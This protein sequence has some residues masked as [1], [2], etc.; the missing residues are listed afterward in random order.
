MKYLKPDF[1][2]MLHDA[3]LDDTILTSFS[4]SIDLV[5]L[6]DAVNVSASLNLTPAD[7]AHYIAERGGLGLTVTGGTLK[8]ASARPA[9]VEGI[10]AD[11]SGVWFDAP[12]TG[13]Y[14]VRWYV[15]GELR[16]EEERDLSDNRYLALTTIDAQPGDVIQIALRV[17]LAISWWSRV[18][19]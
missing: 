14:D 3:G 2:P 13:L 18:Q 5:D 16:H 10:A 11:T 15:N 8:P 12:D 19:L 6:V 17:G 1:V 9:S 4:H 7:L